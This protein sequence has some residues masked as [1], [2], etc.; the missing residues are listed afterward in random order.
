LVDGTSREINANDAILLACGIANPVALKSYLE[1]KVQFYEM[2]Q[3]R[4][5]H[6]YTSSDLQE[7]L[8]KFEVFSVNKTTKL[9][10]TTEKDAVRLTKF[11]EELAGIPSYVIP[12]AHEFLFLQE[13]AFLGQ[14]ISFIR[15]F[16]P[17]DNQN[18]I[19]QD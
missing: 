9:I 8:K 16:E 18:S 1:S 2:S 19:V 5:H 11:K 12:I 14:I 4:D 10:L 15:Q 13:N 7:L 17:R 3:Y 6:I